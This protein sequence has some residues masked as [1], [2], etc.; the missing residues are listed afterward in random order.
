MAKQRAAAMKRRLWILYPGRYLGMRIGPMLRVERMAEFAAAAGHSPVIAADEVD[1]SVLPSGWEGA[2]LNPRLVEQIRPGEAV[3]VSPHLRLPV[4]RALLD[5]AV[6]FDLDLYGV[7]AMESLETM[8]AFSAFRGAQGRFRTALRYKMLLRRAEK[9]YF[10]TEEQVAFVGGCLFRDSSRESGRLA[11]RLPESVLYLPMGVDESPVPE[12]L[13]NPYPRGLEG[14]P[15]FL[16]G[17]GIWAWF[18]LQTLFEAFSILK[19]RTREPALF[20]LSGRNESGIATQDKAVE[21]AWSLA[22]EM[23]LLDSGVFFNQA[24]VG[25]KELPGYLRHCR[26]GILA[27]PLRLESLGSWR[28][29]NLDLLWAG[30]PAVVAG[31]DPLSDRME[32]AGCARIVPANDGRA[33]A[34]AIASIADDDGT[35]AEMC[36]ASRREGDVLAWPRVLEPFLDRLESSRSFTIPGKPPSSWEWARYFAG[37]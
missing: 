30:R 17:G 22:A 16:W 2:S 36:R 9:V 18:D 13:P 15:I 21:R 12:G 33:L 27:N 8:D 24:R 4:L 25:R 1:A 14:R 31:R 10:S 35:W 5:S 3:V 37:M 23:G 19:G 26:A 28:T 11:S 34:D 7:G 6:P 29:R 32:K 20:F